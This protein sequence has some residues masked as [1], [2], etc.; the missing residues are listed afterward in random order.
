M[1]QAH[2]P[3]VDD[4][5]DRQFYLFNAVV[6]AL[7]LAFIGWILL[8]EGVT[9]SQAYAT[10]GGFSVLGFLLVYGLVSIASLRRNLPG[11]S[12]ERRWL[13]GSSSLVAVT[14]VA[15]GYLC[16]LMGQQKAIPISFVVLMAVGWWRMHQT[17]SS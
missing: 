7:A 17:Q 10:L 4:G 1:S 9:A 13:V 12:R 6:S 14:V 8:V 2:S 16:G 5:T 3:L 15:V 11:C